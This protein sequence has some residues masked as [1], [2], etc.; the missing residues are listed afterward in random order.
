MDVVPGWALF[1]NTDTYLP[2]PLMDDMLRKGNNL[3]LAL[4]LD[5][6][7]PYELITLAL[8]FHE[9][10]KTGKRTLSFEKNAMAKRIGLPQDNKMYA[11][12]KEIVDWVYNLDVYIRNDA[13]DRARFHMTKSISYIERQKMFTITFDDEL[14]LLL[15]QQPY[16]QL[17]L[18][19][20]FK[21]ASVTGPSK[22]TAETDEET[23]A[24]KKR[25]SSSKGGS[26]GATAATVA[27]RLYERLKLE[28]YRL[29]YKGKIEVVI[30]ECELRLYLGLY[31]DP[32]LKKTLEINGFHA[33]VVM[34]YY[35]EKRTRFESAKL[36]EARRQKA[37]FL[38]LPEG[39]V[40]LDDEEKKEELKSI[41]KA[42]KRAYSPKYASFTSFKRDLLVPAVE[43]VTE[44]TDIAVTI[45]KTRVTSDGEREVIFTISE[46]A[47]QEQ[48]SAN[49]QKVQEQL[50]EQL[51][52][53]GWAL[54][55]KDIEMLLSLTD[56]DPDRVIY[57]FEVACEY[58]ENE[59][60]IE[61]L[62]IFMRRAL[63]NDWRRRT[64][65]VEGMTQ[66]GSR[67]FMDQA[68]KIIREYPEYREKR[69]REM[70][71]PGLPDLL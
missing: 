52:K 36:E 20:I 49:A 34:R 59:K 71:E 21:L 66:E 13:G 10:Q 35:E 25:K 15:N 47:N 23:P 12:L 7:G 61:D 14:G 67:E 32:E 29:K 16:T 63:E 40:S 4:N 58:A 45:K 55:E 60:V 24:K 43:A 9:V 22:G 27:I 44:Y 38:R 65:M 1:M 68:D 31:D 8:L 3:L 6:G 53:R 54:H 39:E 26:K 48:I 18:R 37:L 51:G 5:G 2:I 50:K 11:K 28:K 62:V 30:L 64:P 19:Y 33:E 41:S 70:N 17:P 46:S 56:N 57:A 69:L 42:E